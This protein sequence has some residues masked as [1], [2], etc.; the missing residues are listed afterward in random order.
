MGVADRVTTFTGSDFGRTLANNGDGSDHGWGSHHF[1]LGSAV[2]PRTWVGSLPAVAVVEGA[3]NVGGGRL[4]PAVAVDQFG[5]TLARWM[6]VA[7]G[8]M[9]TV[10]PNIGNYSVRD[11]GFM[12]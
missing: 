2:K 4:L 1:V 11:L 7:D 9:A 3:D 10:F 6:G 8:Q 12:A 5:A